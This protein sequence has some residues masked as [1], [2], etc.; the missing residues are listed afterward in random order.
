MIEMYK[1]VIHYDFATEND[2]FKLNGSHR[3][4]ELNDRRGV[5]LKSIHSTISLLKHNLNQTKGSLELWFFTL[6]DLSPAS[7]AD[8]MGMNNEF[9]GIYPLLSDSQTPHDM[10][11]AN[12]AI[13]FEKRWHPQ[14]YTK[15]YKGG[16]HYRLEPPIK[17]FTSSE[18]M[19]FKKNQWYQIVVTFNKEAH[20]YRM[21]ANG[22][23]IATES[24]FDD[25]FHYDT[26]ND[27][28]YTGDPTLCYSEMNFY[29]EVLSRQDIQT[30]YK[31]NSTDYNQ[32]IVDHLE[33]TFQGHNRK[34]F[35]WT[36]DN[37]WEEKLSLSL[38]KPED[39]EQFHVQGYTDAP[40]IT[41]EGLLIETPKVRQHSSTLELQVYLWSHMTFEGDLYIEYEFQT[42]R[43][44]GLSLLMVNASGMNREDFLKDYPLRTNGSMVTVYGED[45]RNYH[46]EYYREMNDVRNDIA[47]FGLTKNPYLLP[48][49]YGCLKDSLSHYEWHKLTY[50]Q[51]GNHIIGAIDGKIVIDAKD[52]PT[53]NSGDVYNFGHIAIRCMV[54][55]KLLVRNLK[56]YNKLS[57]FKVL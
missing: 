43:P 3:I 9:Y 18:H 10:S 32:D 52:T 19:D 26:C 24:Q 4:L 2:Q 23:L 30:I 46:W 34:P 21:Y 8:H 11:S 15:F 45:V 39:L 22:V 17:A 50:L 14:F 35:T 12:F 36:L 48:L 7:H 51:R 29:D 20:E 56:V 42:L 28:L 16:L 33:H 40:S 44:G 47:S 1:P 38:T 53:S 5:N 27:V 54:H 57:A 25:N 49:D 13:M 41:D 55:T 6:E 31:S 37:T